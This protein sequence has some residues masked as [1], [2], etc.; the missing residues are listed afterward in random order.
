MFD[1]YSG[2]AMVL[3]DSSYVSDDGTKACNLQQQCLS[4]QQ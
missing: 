2:L 3:L 4:Q 1:T